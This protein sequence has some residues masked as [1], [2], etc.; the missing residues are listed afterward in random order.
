MTHEVTH[1]LRVRAPQPTPNISTPAPWNAEGYPT[2]TGPIGPEVYR[3]RRQRLLE[4]MGTGVAVI[5]AADTIG[6]GDRQD[7][8]FY[9]LTGLE[10]EHGA[11]LMLAPEHPDFKEQL[12]LRALDVEDNRW[13][14][15]RPLLGR[16]VELGTGFAKVKRMNLLAPSLTDAV[17]Q[18]KERELVYLGPV[19]GYTSPIPKQLQVLRDVSARVLHSKIRDAHELLPRMRS[20]HDEH[21]LAIMRRA[22]EI[23]GGGFAAAMR[24]ARPG[25]NES[26][27]QAVFEAHFR[28]NG[29]H[30]NAYNPIVGA[31]LN[32]CVLHYNLNRREMR[33]GDLVLC[34]V[35]CE[36]EMYASDI[37]RTFPVNGRFTPRQ[38][39]VYTVV[40]NAWKAAVAQVRPGA[41]WQQ[42]NDAAR[43]VIDA[44]GFSDEYFHSVGHFVGLYVHD[45]GLQREPLRPGMVI[46]IEPGIYIA[47]E[48]IGVRIEDDILVTES[49]CEVLSASI[50][51]EIHEIEAV[52]AHRA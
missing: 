12:F 38:A 18:S 1:G 29:S 20:V 6:H 47:S 37:T 34:D 5:F 30:S 39:E 25:M 16:G 40:L 33:D 45:A 3:A 8:D 35:G 51:R 32:T 13:H 27:L 52:M 24:A 46:T 43:D 4:Q 44:A 21:E 41:T 7:L 31:G 36:Y 22:V 49:G 2:P 50:P 48:E 17:L 14:G 19:V 23:T 28:A 42:L 26:A 11:A 9:Y 10:F 15:N